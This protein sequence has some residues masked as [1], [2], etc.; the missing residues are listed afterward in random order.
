MRNKRLKQWKKKKKRDWKISKH[1]MSMLECLIN[2]NKIELMSSKIEK[3]E[4]KSS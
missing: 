4:P 2:K 1:R 3:K